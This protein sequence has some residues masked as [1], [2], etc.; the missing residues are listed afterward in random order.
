MLKD[1][2]D[3]FCGFSEGYTFT[4]FQEKIH[5]FL[6]Y[7]KVIFGTGLVIVQLMSQTWGLM[8]FSL[9]QLKKCLL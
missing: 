7:I 2:V 6:E 4:H 5:F 3:I 9:N 8:T 1:R